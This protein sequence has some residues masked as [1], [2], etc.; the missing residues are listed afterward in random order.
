MTWMQNTGSQSPSGRQKK[1][2][3]LTRIAPG[4]HRES[5]PDCERTEFRP[6]ARKSL[7]L[8]DQESQAF[9]MTLRH[10]NS[11][12]RSPLGNPQRGHLPSH[13]AHTHHFSP[14]RR[15]S[16][17]ST[18]FHPYMRSKIAK[19]TAKASLQEQPL[20]PDRDRHSNRSFPIAP[21]R[22]VA[23]QHPLS[24]YKPSYRQ[25]LTHLSKIH[26]WEDHY[27]DGEE[28]SVHQEQQPQAQD[29]LLAQIQGECIIPANS[30]STRST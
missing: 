30:S 29:A 4:P 1:D 11:P 27:V 6:R 16:P 8:R 5:S 24:K 19:K 14:I 20:Q 22:D 28:S 23:A 25:P 9:H 13:D 18:R 21:R 2:S 15:H 26:G 7:S 12:A 10:R 17:K 3:F